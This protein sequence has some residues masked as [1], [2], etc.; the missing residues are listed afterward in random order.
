MPRASVM[1]EAMRDIGYSFE[2]AV[3]DII[4][5]SI[6]AG[7]RNI[8]LR[9]GWVADLPWIAVIDDGCGMSRDE[10]LEA[11]RP[12]SKDP[13]HERAAHDLGR[14]GLGLKT[15]SF[16]QCRELTVLTRRSEELNGMRWDLD[17]V[18]VT[19]RWEITEVHP[20]E[21]S[22][23]PC[24]LPPDESGTLVLWRK[25]DRLELAGMG[26]V[27]HEAVNEMM[28]A[29]QRHL[30][31]IFHR[32][33]AGELGLK[34]VRIS[35]NGTDIEPYDPF[36]ELTIATQKFPLE[37]VRFR[38]SE[39]KIQAYVLPHHSKVSAKEYERLAGPEGYLRNQGF[40]IYRNRRLI[41]WG[42]WFRLARQ[43]ELTKLARVRI[44]IPN[45][46]DHHWGIDVR[47]ARA[48]PPLIVK[49]RL[50]Q[51]IEQIRSGA[52]RP[53]TQRGRVV[54]ETNTSPVWVRKVHND[55]IEYA[56]ND[57][58][59]LLTGLLNDL[60][61][62][63]RLRLRQMIKMFGQTFPA[64]AFFS[65]YSNTPKQI[66]TEQ[67]DMDVMLALAKMLVQANP[68]LDQAGLTTVLATMEPFSRHPDQIG[69]I[70]RR[71]TAD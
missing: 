26:E 37:V 12:G 51:V 70:A 56:I 35:V 22:D 43:E 13:R 17:R 10:L 28:S 3:A 40:Y 23:M 61:V 24:S 9:F 52:K 16:S 66:E 18:S 65:D 48:H 5:N 36:A 63:D 57:E 20:S 7:A 2:S 33:L 14:F 41:I 21:M 4:D 27:G 54:V 44:D 67:P 69:V 15:A 19:N 50:R 68:D 58:H 29:I 8:D 46:T 55:R 49:N 62:G 42:S 45:N 59:P 31:R 47:K 38:D 11:M 25:I 30:S 34:R 32:F 6:A 64:A 39:V 71:A 60:H 53:Y 1:I